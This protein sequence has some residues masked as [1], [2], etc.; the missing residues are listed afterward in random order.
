[1]TS[2]KRMDKEDIIKVAFEILREKGDRRR[3]C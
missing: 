1:M 3:K 2:V